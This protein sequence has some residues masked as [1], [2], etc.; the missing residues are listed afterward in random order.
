MVD[1]D[2]SSLI[3]NVSLFSTL[4]EDELATVTRYSGFYNFAAGEKVFSEGS[5]AEELYIIRAGE[6]VI[7]KHAGGNEDETKLVDIARFVEGDCFGELGMLDSRPRSET[8]TA[9]R[10]SELLIF[11]KRGLRFQELLQQHPSVFAQILHKLL[12]TIAGRIRTTNAL[13]SDRSPWIQDLRRQLLSD[14]LTGLYNRTFLEEDLATLLPGYGSQTSFVMIKPDQFKLI[15]DNWGHEAGDSLLKMLAIAIKGSIR[16]TDIA[17]RYRGNEI[18]VV[19]PDTDTARAREIAEDIRAAIPRIDTTP[20]TGEKKVIVT[21]SLGI[22]TYPRDAENNRQ[23]V[24]RAF[25]KMFQAREA[26][27]DRVFFFEGG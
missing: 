23:L 26:G 6:V 15:N 5:I 22:A 2:R 4:K 27:G 14:E 8:A 24:E 9:T 21:A 19:L 20:I 16:D 3:K 18:G 1:A 10:D 25:E 12:A 7:S 11:P 13:I 17:V